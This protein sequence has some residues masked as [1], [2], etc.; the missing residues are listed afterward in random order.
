VKRFE[1]WEIPRSSSYFE[2]DDRGLDD[3]E[4]VDESRRESRD[5]DDGDKW[6]HDAFFSAMEADKQAEKEAEKEKSATD[7]A[8]DAEMVAEDNKAVE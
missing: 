5:A 6:G 7:T 1:D 4:A 8:G 3:F 2:H